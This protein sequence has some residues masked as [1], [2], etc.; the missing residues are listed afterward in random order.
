[1]VSNGSTEQ[2]FDLSSFIVTPF[3]PSGTMLSYP[4]PTDSGVTIDVTTLYEAMRM[5]SEYIVSLHSASEI[6]FSDLRTITNGFNSDGTELTNTKINGYRT[7]GSVGGSSQAIPG[8]APWIVGVREDGVAEVGRIIDFHTSFKTGTNDVTCRLTCTGSNYLYVPNFHVSTTLSGPT[9]AGL[10][11]RMTAKETK[12]TTL[13]TDVDGLT[14]QMSTA[15]GTIA[16]HT[17]L[18]SSASSSAAAVNAR[19]TRI[20]GTYYYPNGYDDPNNS[21]FRTLEWVVDYMLKNVIPSL[22][23]LETSNTL[24]S[25]LLGLHGAANVAEVA[26]MLTTLKTLEAASAAHG[27]QLSAHAITLE[28][29]LLTMAEL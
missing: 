23:E 3:D 13:R 27:V 28:A 19:V 1:V 22:G 25:W 14:T 29:N 4:Y 26:Y 12:S 17:A 10:M 5:M 21:D 2:I 8:P 18:I 11:T 6:A 24:Q 9:I 15:E 16:N 20:M 7:Y